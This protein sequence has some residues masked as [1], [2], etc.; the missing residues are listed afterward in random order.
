[1]SSSPNKGWR[2]CAAALLMAGAVHAAQDDAARARLKTGSDHLERGE[3]AAAIR[4]LRSAVAADPKL[5][6]AH[7]LLGRAYL[8]E[9]SVALVAEAKAELQQALDLDPSLLWAR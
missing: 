8:E 4:E 3:V 5:A 2:L 6:A 1:M 7:M 9:R